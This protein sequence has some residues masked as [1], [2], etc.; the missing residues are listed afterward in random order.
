MWYL[1]ERTELFWRDPFEGATFTPLTDFEGAEQHAAISRDGQFV[2]FI[3]DREAR[4]VW[5]AWVRQ[6]GATSDFKLQP[7]EWQTAGTAQSRDPDGRIH[8]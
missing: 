8:T 6:I 2:V 4:G 3:A 1:A 7:D 5:D